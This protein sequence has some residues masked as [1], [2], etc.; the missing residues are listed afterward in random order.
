MKYKI[1]AIAFDLGG[2]FFTEGKSVLTSKLQA[3]LGYDPDKVVPLLKSPKSIELRKGLISDEE[4]WFW[5]QKQ[6]TGD[7]DWQ[8][9]RDSWY[10]SYEVNKDIADLLPILRKKVEL[11]SFSANDKERIEYLD[12]KYN[13]RN[14]FDIEVFSYV[15]N[16]CKPEPEFVTKMIDASGVNPNQIL[17]IDDREDALKPAKKLGVRTFQYSPQKHAEFLT[18]LSEFSLI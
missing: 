8:F 17:Y 10:D 13:F 12:K 16:L 3:T 4:F 6:I 7:C 14:L 15:Y 5:I 9:I 1:E 18:L 11:I 2:V